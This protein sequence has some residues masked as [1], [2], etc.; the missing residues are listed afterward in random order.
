MMA[1]LDLVEEK[2]DQALICTTACNQVIT[3]N[4]NKRFQP[5]TF[6]V[7]DLVLKK[8]WVQKPKLGSFGPKWEGAFR[9][10]SIVRLGTYHLTNQD[11]I[12][13]GHP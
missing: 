13:L 5:R 1:E 10:I 4:Y 6:N 12:F 11:G 9:I 8:V 7:G 3:K 2:R